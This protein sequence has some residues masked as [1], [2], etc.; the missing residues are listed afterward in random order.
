M[1]TGVEA[2]VSEEE[3]CFPLPAALGAVG[4]KRVEMKINNNSN[5]NNK[6]SQPCVP[7]C[8]LLYLPFLLLSL[9]PSPSTLQRK[10]TQ[11]GHS[12]IV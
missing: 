7:C 3:V 1:Q 2:Q 11:C 10:D 4:L 5:N 6:M 9:V 8:P 12:P